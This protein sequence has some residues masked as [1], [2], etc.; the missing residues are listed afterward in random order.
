MAPAY[1]NELKTLGDH[2]RKRRLDLG[3]FQKDNK[4]F[5]SWLKDEDDIPNYF[6]RSGECEKTVLVF[7]SAVP[8]KS[9]AFYP[10]REDVVILAISSGVYAIE[11]DARKHQNFQPVYKGIDPSFVTEGNTLYIKDSEN[12]FRIEL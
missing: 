12:L 7:D 5:A 3:L 8:I 9:L 11:I 1:P 6:C 4:I 2:L 10:N